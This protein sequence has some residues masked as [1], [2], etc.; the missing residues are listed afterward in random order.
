MDRK[1]ENQ[2]QLKKTASDMVKSL[3]IAYVVTGIFLLILTLLLYKMGLSEQNVNIG[4][5]LIYVIATFSG[6]FVMGKLSIT[7]QF[8]WGLL[9]G[10]LYW[11]LLMLISLGIYHSLQAEMWSLLTTL[12]LCAG[13]GM[14]GG[15]V[16]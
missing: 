2:F 7:H 9:A 16:S 4:V 1:N 3:L 6:G 11:G 13:G 8:L 10:V 12:L 15:M 5:I 14:L